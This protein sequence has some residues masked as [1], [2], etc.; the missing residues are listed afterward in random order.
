M[1]SRYTVPEMND[2]WSDKNRFMKYSVFHHAYLQ[3]ILGRSVI[4]EELDPDLEMIS[5]FEKKTKHELQASLLEFE[6]RIDPD[7]EEAKANIHKYLTSSDVIDTVLSHTIKEAATLLHSK[8]NKCLLA[9]EDLSTKTEHI[10]TIGRTHGRHAIPMNLEN[11]FKREWQDLLLANNDMLDNCT[12]IPGKLAGPVGEFNA[13]DKTIEDINS[14]FELSHFVKAG[15]TSQALSRSYHAKAVFDIALLGSLVERLVTNIRLLSFN[16]INEL[17]EGFTSNQAGSSSMPHK[18][19]PIGCENLVGIARLLRSYVTPSLE[20][21]PL[22]L[23]R[24]MSHSS[25]ERVILPDAFNLAYYMFTRLEDILS[26]LK[27][28]AEA[29]DANLKSY[30]NTGNSHK[31]ISNTN[32]PRSQ[33]YKLAQEKY[34]GS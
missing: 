30:F 33:A 15:Y 10:N 20:N 22:W 2:I 16:E 5:Y 19:N 13:N 6:T 32:L 17:S 31:D 25:V 3:S 12:N 26:N 9:L 18:K 8:I 34:L 1:I 27:I 14:Y 28:N 4:L 21:V 11:R 24:D 7:D 23:E 29:I